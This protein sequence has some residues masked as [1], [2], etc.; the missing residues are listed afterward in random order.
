MATRA[1]GTGAGV[2]GACGK[3]VGGLAAWEAGV[4]MW[5]EG[6]CP[7]GT[8]PL[9]LHPA[10]RARQGNATRRQGSAMADGDRE[11]AVEESKSES[12]VQS[13]QPL[14]CLLQHGCWH[15]WGATSPSRG[16]SVTGQG[17][18]APG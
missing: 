10:S 6:T 14:P 13:P 9:S 5:R 16:H 17:T 7:L 8:K 12:S 11:V 2:P 4:G 1:G 15:H 3:G 18:P